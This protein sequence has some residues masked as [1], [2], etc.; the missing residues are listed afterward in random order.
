MYRRCSV[1]VRAYLVGECQRD[2]GPSFRRAWRSH[3][4]I[5]W[6][7]LRHTKSGVFIGVSGERF[8]GSLARKSVLGL[9]RGPSIRV[10]SSECG[11]KS[12]TASTACKAVSWRLVMGGL[13]SDATGWENVS[14]ARRG[15]V[16]RSRGPRN[17]S[18]TMVVGGALRG[19]LGLSP[20]M[21]VSATG[22]AVGFRGP[23]T[24]AELDEQVRGLQCEN[25]RL[26][27]EVLLWR[28]WYAEQYVGQIQYLAERIAFL[29]GGPETVLVDE[30]EN[31]IQ[32]ATSEGPAETA[33][34]NASVA[35][36]GE[37]R[38]I[39][40]S[41][42]VA[43]DDFSV[44][45]GRKDAPREK[46]RSPSPNRICRCLC[47]PRGTL[48]EPWD[49]CDV[50]N[51]ANG[52]S[53]AVL[54]TSLTVCK[55][56]QMSCARPYRRR[57][58][59]PGTRS[60]IL[61]GSITILLDALNFEA[62]NMNDVST[63]SYLSSRARLAYKMRSNTWC[64]FVEPATHSEVRNAFAWFVTYEVLAAWEA[65]QQRYGSVGW[66]VVSKAE[67]LGWLHGAA[68]GSCVSIFYCM[69]IEGFCLCAAFLAGA[70]SYSVSLSFH[71]VDPRGFGSMG[72][73]C[74]SFRCVIFL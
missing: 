23:V 11:R 58:S 57:C 10:S 72:V 42:N 3:K 26:Q 2:D 17:C 74:F 31:R 28:R 6:S 44:G 59:L 67:D 46:R 21:S 40:T 50:L 16:F 9:R 37:A 34:G 56:S 32:E 18:P 66:F 20:S 41:K 22:S 7:E 55:I 30:L 36:D 43:A 29:S 13:P 39:E 25:Q 73:W 19:G 65:V 35:G 38:P 69:D 12:E 63:S 27:E 5:G 70:T 51:L 64:P 61:C 52:E 14:G 49:S 62:G 1:L 68:I 54:V 45:G 71:F 33:S 53:A 48:A 24:K 8:V 47:Y 15:K 60:L 4:R